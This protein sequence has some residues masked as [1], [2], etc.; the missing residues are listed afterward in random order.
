[1]IALFIA[2][3]IGLGFAFYCPDQYR[4]QT[5]IGCHFDHYLVFVP[6]TFI[7]M[8]AVESNSARFLILPAIAILSEFLQ[9]WTPNH[10]PEF[11]GGAA[12]LVAVLI[13]ACVYFAWLKI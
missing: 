3:I 5:Y 13:G 12:S 11:Y 8:R 10:T 9:V 6:W 2:S 1:M 4:P 7:F